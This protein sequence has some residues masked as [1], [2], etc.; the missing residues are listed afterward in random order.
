MIVGLL[1]PERKPR[2]SLYAPFHA[3]AP[4]EAG[5]CLTSRCP[6]ATG[7]FL[8]RHPQRPGTKT[9]CTDPTPR[10]GT[11]RSAVRPGTTQPGPCPGSPPLPHRRRPRVHPHD[12]GPP[13]RVRMAS[14]ASPAVAPVGRPLAPPGAPA[15]A[16]AHD[17]RPGRVNGVVRPCRPQS[18]LRLCQ[19]RCRGALDLRRPAVAP[20]ATQRRQQ[21]APRRAHLAPCQP[22]PFPRINRQRRSGCRHGSCSSNSSA[23]ST[24][25]FAAG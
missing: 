21:P 12:L 3:L 1:Q 7:R 8:P 11:T 20:S 4:W 16:R 19:Q 13:G 6:C 25:C 2:D 18:Q 10:S 9:L 15:A 23:A 22:Q 5:T 24:S 17:P 14:R